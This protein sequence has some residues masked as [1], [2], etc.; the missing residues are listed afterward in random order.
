MSG[1]D[2]KR[3]SIY[4]ND[5]LAGSVAG[6]ELARRSASS[7]RDSEF[8]DVLANLVSEIEADSAAL[9]EVMERLDV[10]QDRVKSTAAWAGEKLGRLKLNGQLTGYSPL[11]R[12][13]ELEGLHIGIN[14]KL[15]LWQSLER[16]AASEPRLEGIDF[17][18]LADRARKQLSD[19]EPHR[20]RAGELALGS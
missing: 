18:T 10:G 2:Q 9:R 8:G 4:L 17:S 3:I 1:I 20:L 11:S 5:H 12:L 16:V 7:N 6:L 14:G 19:L 13:I 15:S